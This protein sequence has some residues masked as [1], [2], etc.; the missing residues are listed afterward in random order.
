MFLYVL[1][2]GFDRIML[3]C[4]CVFIA[5]FCVVRNPS[6]KHPQEE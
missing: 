4:H 6:C 5:F 3:G 2:L 1:Q